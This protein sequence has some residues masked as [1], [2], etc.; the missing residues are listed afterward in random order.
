MKGE[1]SSV[2]HHE[3]QFLTSCSF[4]PECSV[5][6]QE[7]PSRHKKRHYIQRIGRRK[8]GKTARAAEE[9]KRKKETQGIRRCV[10]FTPS[11]IS[12]CSFLAHD[13]FLVSKRNTGSTYVNI[14]ALK[15]FNSSLPLD[16]QAAD[17]RAAKYIH[18]RVVGLHSLPSVDSAPV[19]DHSQQSLDIAVELS[20]EIETYEGFVR[21]DRLYC[22]ADEDFDNRLDSHRRA[23][24]GYRQALD[25]YLQGPSAFTAAY[26][27][28]ALIFQ[29]R[30]YVF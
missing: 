23:I 1:L 27:D 2:I 9:T 12:Y 25:L 26:E 21:E 5:S 28:H 6:P 16:A 11:D 3:A 30:R 15:S 22:W 19:V 7:L 29:G 17:L 10:Q 14:L 8:I 20:L 13:F 18:D 24:A 4:L